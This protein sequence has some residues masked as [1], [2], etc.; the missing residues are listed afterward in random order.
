[1]N[2]WQEQTEWIVS[3]FLLLYDENSAEVQENIREKNQNESLGYFKGYL[4]R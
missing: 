2:C 1:M 4:R 3:A